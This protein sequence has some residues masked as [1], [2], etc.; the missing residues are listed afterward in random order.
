M[1]EIAKSESFL[2]LTRGGEREGWWIR[3][4]VA[5]ATQDLGWGAPPPPPPSI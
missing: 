4:G 5:P 3:T 1:A 2:A